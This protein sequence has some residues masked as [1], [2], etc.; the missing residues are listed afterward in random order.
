MNEK[1]HVFF[2][3]DENLIMIGADDCNDEQ[4]KRIV[5]RTE[6]LLKWELYEFL[7]KL[8]DFYEEEE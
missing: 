5:W 1:I 8:D 4:L 3:E 2:D 6:A 7:D